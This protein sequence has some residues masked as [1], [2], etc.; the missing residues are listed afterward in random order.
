MDAQYQLT[1][2]I[3]LAT[4][5]DVGQTGAIQR[6]ITGVEGVDGNIK[7]TTP[8]DRDGRSGVVVR[9]KAGALVVPVT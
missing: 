8:D 4:R 6:K 3:S 7:Y 9:R 5:G 2:K 1:S